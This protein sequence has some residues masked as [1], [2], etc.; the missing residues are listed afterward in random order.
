MISI[1]DSFFLSSCVLTNHCV[2]KVVTK[3]EVY[4]IYAL[5]YKGINKNVLEVYSY[6]KKFKSEIQL[7]FV[8]K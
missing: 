4:R 5:V 6:L 7:I 1:L 3:P 8:V 2:K